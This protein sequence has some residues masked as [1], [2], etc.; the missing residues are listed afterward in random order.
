MTRMVFYSFLLFVPRIG[1]VVSCFF[2]LFDLI[3]SEGITL[4]CLAGMLRIR[5][6]RVM[7]GF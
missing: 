4:Y 2:Y 3:I 1:S 7:V 5:N 6:C